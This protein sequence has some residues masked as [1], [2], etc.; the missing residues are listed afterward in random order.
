MALS[1]IDMSKMTT[2]TLGV[3]NGGTGLTSGTTDQIL[4]FTGTTTLA[5][6]AEAAGGKILQV[7]NGDY[8]TQ[9]NNSTDDLAD[10]GVSATITPAATSSKIF[11]T[12]DTQYS[13]AA[14][15]SQ[16]FMGGVNIFADKGGAG[17]NKISGGGSF[18]E[19]YALGFTSQA[20]GVER[21]VNGRWTACMLW[22][23]STT[24]ACTFKLYSHNNATNGLSCT[25]DSI[26][27]HINLMEVGA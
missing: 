19:Y 17:Y 18:G 26:T 11:I 12:A 6:A 14:V 21:R 8:S 2:G 23:P 5:S 3:A 13:M 4:K 22:S 25:Y 7:T 10:I 1:K 20:T 27:T 15:G 24:S 9:H 16:T